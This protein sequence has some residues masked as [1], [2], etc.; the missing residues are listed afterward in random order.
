MKICDKGK[1]S[2][3][4][5]TRPTPTQPAKSYP[6][7]AGCFHAPSIMPR[8]R[9]SL[10]HASVTF[11]VRGFLISTTN[12]TTRIKVSTDSTRPARHHDVIR[13]PFVESRF[14]GWDDTQAHIHNIDVM[15]RRC[16]YRVFFQRHQS[17]PTNV[18]L[19][20][21]G[22]LVVMRVGAKNT[23][24]VVNARKGDSGR[25]R[26]LAQRIA[27]HLATFQFEEGRRIRPIIHL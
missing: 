17:L 16:R 19:G 2:T 5:Q 1:T 11:Q 9:K 6:P 26:T 21:Q 22:D 25:I 14:V 13:T 18:V 23:E 24:N 20:I 3:D 4:S 8:T 12:T 10:P 7:A 27:P 15:Y